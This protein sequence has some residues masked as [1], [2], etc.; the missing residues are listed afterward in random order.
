MDTEYEGTRF[1]WSDIKAETNLVDHG[2]SFFEAATV[3]GDSLG[4]IY[5]D[6][7]HSSEE[8]RYLTVGRSEQ[9]RILIVSYTE[10]GDIIRII[11]ARDAEP[12]EIREYEEG[13]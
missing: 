1:E 8:R 4:V 7:E 3:F 2:V 12:R 11:S 9:D 6:D 10:R 13:S 5:D